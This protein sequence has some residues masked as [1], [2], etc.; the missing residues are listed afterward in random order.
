MPQP[1]KN[2]QELN[3]TGGIGLK[4]IQK[5]LTLGY[6][7]EDYDLT[8]ENHDNLYKVQLKLKVK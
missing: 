2:K 4:N 6:P 8:I 3:K 1:L 7:P 5:R